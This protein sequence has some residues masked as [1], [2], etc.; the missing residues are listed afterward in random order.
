[1]E[2]VIFPLSALFIFLIFSEIITVEVF[3]DDVFHFNINFNIF[4]ISLYPEK[5]IER[6]KKREKRKKQKNK[7]KRSDIPAIKDAFVYLLSYSTVEINDIRLYMK[8][9]PGLNTYVKEGALYGA[10]YS[11]LYILRLNSKKFIQNNIFISSSDNNKNDLYLDA[12]ITF[13][14]FRVIFAVAVFAK[15]KFFSKKEKKIVRR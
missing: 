12:K 10:L 15:N 9:A 11:I 7:I 1:M 13:P 2:A 5:A 8:S 6:A 3:Y 14:L 4:G